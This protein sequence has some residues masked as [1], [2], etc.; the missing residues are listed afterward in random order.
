MVRNQQIYAARGYRETH[1]EVT[2]RYTVVHMAKHLP[3]LED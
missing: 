2:P 3:R 1:R